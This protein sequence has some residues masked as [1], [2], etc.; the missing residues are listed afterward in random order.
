MAEAGQK[1]QKGTRHQANGGQHRS[2]LALGMGSMRLVAGVVYR[3][4]AWLPGFAKA[5][6]GLFD[7]RTQSVRNGIRRGAS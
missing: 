3:R 1:K 4:V 2:I 6:R 5:L 7:D